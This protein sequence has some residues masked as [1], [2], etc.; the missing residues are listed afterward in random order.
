MVPRSGCSRRKAQK[1]TRVELAVAVAEVTGPEVTVA[2]SV[3]TGPGVV[4]VALEAGRGAA[5]NDLADRLPGVEHHAA[6]IE[7]GRRADDVAGA[8]GGAVGLQERAAVPPRELR[9]VTG[10]GH[11]VVGHVLASE[12]D[13]VDLTYE[14]PP[15]GGADH[16]LRRSRRSGR[17]EHEQRGPRIKPLLRRRDCRPA[18][19]YE[20]TCVPRAAGV[21]DLRHAMAD[22]VQRSP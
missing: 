7:A 22:T 10:R 20:K 17:E 15:A 21:E 16:R 12:S 6:G 1:G 14:R 8:L 18:V 19:R 11:R 2:Q 13:R 3:L 9:A 5:G 4:V